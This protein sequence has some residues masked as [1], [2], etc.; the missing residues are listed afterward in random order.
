MPLEDIDSLHIENVGSPAS[1]R[2]ESAAEAKS[3]R[4]KIRVSLSLALL[5]SSLTTI[6]VLTSVATAYWVNIRN[7][8]AATDQSISQRQDKLEDEIKS[9]RDSE[10]RMWTIIQNKQDK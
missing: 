1:R 9:M 4:E 7:R 5:I 8:Q 6:V 10:G 2:L 3:D